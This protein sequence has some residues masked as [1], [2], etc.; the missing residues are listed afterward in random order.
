MNRLGDC[1]FHARSFV[2]SLEAYTQVATMKA[3]DTDY[4]LLQSGYANGLLHKYNEKVLVLNDL[5]EQ[6]PNSDYADDA[7]YEMAR[8]QL[9]QNNNKEAIEIYQLLL[10][11]YSS[12]PLVTA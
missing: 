8:A 6:Y 1:L 3:D 10:N 11:D 4:A 5:I 7:L 12:S 2:E 9:M